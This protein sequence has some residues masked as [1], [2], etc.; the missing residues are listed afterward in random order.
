MRFTWPAALLA[1][2]VL[3]GCGSNSNGSQ[4]AAPPAPGPATTTSSAAK[5]SGVVHCPEGS[6][7]A[8]TLGI[9]VTKAEE[10]AR[11]GDK[12]V[13]CDYNGTKAGG[14]RTGV[15]EA[16]HNIRRVAI[17]GQSATGPRI[18]TFPKCDPLSR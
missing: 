3:A 7:I 1:L 15:T 14:E 18:T 9:T 11:S 4:Q 17:R 5:T 12:T 6:V 8:D 10:A 16:S 13:V 2:A